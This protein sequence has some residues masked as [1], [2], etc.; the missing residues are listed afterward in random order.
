MTLLSDA[1]T[2]LL[3]DDNQLVRSSLAMM[4]EDLDFAVVEAETGQ[5]AL[6]V[7]AA[8]GTLYAA[9]VD[10][11][12]PDMDG[13][14]LARRLRE[15]KPRLRLVMASGQPID[16]DALAHIPGPPVNMLLKPFTVKQLDELL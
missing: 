6:D 11:R 1:E 16:S 13:V 8:S 10:F 3:V 7:L 2:I 12:L 4:L 14:E 5:E 9:L 15:L